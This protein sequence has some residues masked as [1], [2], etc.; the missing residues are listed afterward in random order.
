[1]G[2]NELAEILDVALG[3]DAALQESSEAT[4]VELARTW[5]QVSASLR[6]AIDSRAAER[7]SSLEKSLAR[8]QADEETRTVRLLEAF[9]QSLRDVLGRKDT[10]QQLTFADLDSNERGQLEQ[11]RAAWQV[12][13]DALSGEKAAEIA[14]LARRYQSVQVLSFP[15]AVVYLVP[16]GD[17]N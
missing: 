2:V 6:A 14:A 8:R 10:D 16:A 13:L 1:M 5:P 11:D 9:E 12:R 4:R 7:Q 3:P 17:S 15:A